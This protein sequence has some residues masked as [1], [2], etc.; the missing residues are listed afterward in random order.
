MTPPRHI[1]ILPDGL[2]IL[3]AWLSAERRGFFRDLLGSEADPEIVD[4]AV[5]ALADEGS[6]VLIA[7][8]IGGAVRCAMAGDP[9]VRLRRS[10]GSVR[11]GMRGS[12]AEHH[13]DL[14]RIELDL[15]GHRIDW[16]VP[17]T[18]VTPVR[19]REV[20]GDETLDPRLLDHPTADIDADAGDEDEDAVEVTERGSTETGG[21]PTVR[22]V[23]CPAGHPNPI[24]VTRC[25]R[26]GAD[27]VDPTVH[28]VARPVLARLV[29]DS[30]RIV[31]VDRPQVIG[32][33]PD[34]ATH[35]GEPPNPI[36]VS[37]PDGAV[38][39]TH[40]RLHVEGWDLL[41]EDTGSLNGTEVRTADGTRRRLREFDPTP[42]GPGC[43]IVLGGDEGFEIES[44]EPG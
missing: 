39:R 26:C 5:A 37:S 21:A 14:D 19:D 13:D 15:D 22:A 33:R 27:L 3:P 12:W 11:T 4:A 7:A 29:F 1:T 10:D 20:I 41:I 8:V 31:E 24:T 28:T 2:L 17:P 16:T 6:P 40:V 9:P 23:R 30:G 38:S 36:T 25:R 18:G 44:V 32:R 43:R 42:V 34:P 35:R